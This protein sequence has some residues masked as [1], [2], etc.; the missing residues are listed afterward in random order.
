LPS[1]G[2]NNKAI[3]KIDMLDNG[4]DDRDSKDEREDMSA[5]HL[6]KNK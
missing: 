3:N 5:F 1:N 6:W 4:T 2:A